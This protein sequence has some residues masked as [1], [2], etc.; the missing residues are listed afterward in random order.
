MSDQVFMLLNKLDNK[1]DKL[2]EKFDNM[3]KTQIQQAASLDMHIRR[4]EIAE[5]NIEMIRGDIKPLTSHVQMVKGMGKFIALIS[6]VAGIA[7][8][9]FAIFGG[10]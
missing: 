1:L 3:E 9:L 5:E 10:K 7:A 6:T 2:D 8:G 4:T